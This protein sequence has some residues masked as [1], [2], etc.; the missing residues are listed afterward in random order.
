MTLSAIHNLAVEPIKKRPVVCDIGGIWLCQLFTTLP[1]AVC[2]QQRCL[3]YRGD[4]TLS[5]IHNDAESNPNG[6]VVVC[7]IGG[8]WLCQLFTTEWNFCYLLTGCL[9][10]RG[11]MTLSAIHNFSGNANNGA[12][13][14]CDIGEIWLCLLI[15]CKYK[16]NFLVEGEKGIGLEY[17]GWVFALEFVLE[18]V[19]GNCEILCKGHGLE[20][21]WIWGIRQY[22]GC[23]DFLRV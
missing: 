11:D 1:S 22:G 3:W 16:K 18:F 4:M 17:S 21:A 19:L 13:V 10:Y 15:N 14:V 23:Q 6:W 8:I 12:N 2:Q 7:D 5:A 20:N 9:W